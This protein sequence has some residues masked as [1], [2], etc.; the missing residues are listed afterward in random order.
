MKSIIYDIGIAIVDAITSTVE[1]VGWGGLLVAFLAYILI[2]AI[3]ADI[4]E[5]KI[6]GILKYICRKIYFGIQ[7][8]A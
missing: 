2:L 5:A 1:L 7:K 4:L 8:K 3:F 6:A